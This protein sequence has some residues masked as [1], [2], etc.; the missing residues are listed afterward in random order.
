MNIKDFFTNFFE[1]RILTRD[2]EFNAEL[3]NHYIGNQD[4]YRLRYINFHRINEYFERF[5]PCNIGVIDF[6]FAPFKFPIGMSREEGFKVLSYLT[7]NIERIL[8]INPSY[9]SVKKLDEAIDLERLAFRRVNI[10]VPNSLDKV[11]DLYTVD[12]RI[13]LFKRSEFYSRYFEWYTTGIT[14]QEVKD[15]YNRI[16]ID[17]YDLRILDS[18]ENQ[19]RSL[20]LENRQ[21]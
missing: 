18:E 20:K 2:Y 16:G 12:G 3:E 17:F 21:P 11:L 7:D 15:I 6:Y 10:D 5:N 1:E 8:N 14:F 9:T 19:S 13:L 4:I